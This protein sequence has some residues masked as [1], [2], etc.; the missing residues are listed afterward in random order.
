MK[1]YMLPGTAELGIG[2]VVEG[3][4]RHLPTFGVEYINKPEQADILVTHAGWQLDDG[5]QP[6]VTHCHGLYPTATLDKADRYYTAN[7][8]VLEN[9]RTSRIVTVPSE[10]VADIFARDML[11]RPEVLPHGIDVEDWNIVTDHGNYVLWGKGHAPGVVDQSLVSTL[12][13]RMPVT[14]FVTTFGEDLDNVTVLGK[15]PFQSIKANIEHAGVYLATTKET[16]GIQTLEAMA[17][18]VP[19]V[20]YDFGGTS[21]IVE[22]LHTGWLVEPGD[23]DGLVD[24][25]VWGLRGRNC[26]GKNCRQVIEEKYSWQ[27]VCEQLYS[28]YGSLEVGDDYDV[29]VSV[30]IPCYNYGHVVDKAIESV[31]NQDFG[32]TYEVIVIDDGSTDDSLEVITRY[33]DDLVIVSKHNGGVAEARNCGIRVASGKY[34]ACLDADDE[35]MPTF[36]K[37]LVP[38]L[39]ADRG[40]GIA[41]G[42]LY[43]VYENGVG[44][45]SEWPPEYCFKRHSKGLNQVPS[46]CVFRRE[47]WERAGGYRGR[48]SPAEDAELWLRIAA[49]GFG[50][51]KVTNE[52]T[53]VY[54]VH[55][56]S[57]SRVMKEPD[58]NR[59]KPW[60]SD[61]DLAP[62]GAVAC[63]YQYDSY[64]VRNYDD[65][66]VTV[67]VP[68]G[69]GHE[70]VAYKAVD[71]VWRQSLPHWELI[72]VNDSGKELTQP[73]T[74]IPLARAYPFV[75]QV[76]VDCRNV[77]TSRNV[78]AGLAKSEFLV[79]LDAD[80]VLESDFLSECV[81]AYNS[82]EMPHYVYT[83]W[84]VDKGNGHIKTTKA[85]NFSCENIRIR[86][87][88]PVTSLV[89]RE[90][91]NDVG[92]FD[93][94]LGREGW[95]DW[96]YYLK[97]VLMEGHSGVRITKPLL[98]YTFGTGVRRDDCAERV[99]ELLPIIRER[100]KE[101]GCRRC[102]QKKSSNTRD[103]GVVQATALD[104]VD[105]M[106]H[107]GGSVLPNKGVRV[108][109]VDGEDYVRV[110]DDG[111]NFGKH[112][113]IGTVSKK[114]YGR[115]RHGE[116]FDMLVDDYRA[117]SGRFELVRDEVQRQELDRPVSPSA[118]RPEHAVRG[119]NGGE[120]VEEDEEY[121]EVDISK[122]TIDQIKALELGPEEAAIAY[123][124]EAMSK[125][126]KTLLAYLADVAGREELQQVLR[127]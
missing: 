22:H 51:E 113:V 12:A 16:F 2:R 35:M 100:Y 19:V 31:L 50:V 49:V 89:P 37:M 29:D 17:A 40:L 120:E 8:N 119:G 64:P 42:A 27:P 76:D 66:W 5:L 56:G 33:K 82:L 103:A 52:V 59:D 41:Y 67:V 85:Q 18:G 107:G 93:E 117:V 78:G 10:W 111:G 124:V 96:D 112:H 65:P 48:Y 4:R 118:S 11:Y 94:E 91:H 13:R 63:E 9:V 101:M 44:R 61:I 81:A 36:L 6:D 38:P 68:V 125:G 47:A 87:I 20:G 69:P 15:L 26:I 45:K 88:H 122:M 62:F 102:G 74:G 121:V 77:S 98:T 127:R 25:I 34:I 73:N 116:E 53:Y 84:Y 7:A 43:A 21:D 57:L 95:E 123:E 71:S 99:D 30:I 108:T 70:D 32:G 60:H 54:N 23:I 72:V 80:D 79:F 105:H 83:D 110:R 90:W 115:K 106:L 114:R 75:Q 104:K 28:L 3:Y 55:S 14:Q 86:A 39:E 24:G 92:G 46:A 97:M 109:E 126:R 1:I 58:W